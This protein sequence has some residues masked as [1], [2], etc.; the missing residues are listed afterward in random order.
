LA[1]AGWLDLGLLGTPPRFFFVLIHLCS[2]AAGMRRFGG[3][4]AQI[5][6][7]LQSSMLHCMPRPE[8]ID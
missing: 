6:E 4:H 8:S 2:L 1:D 7:S 3:G 5:R